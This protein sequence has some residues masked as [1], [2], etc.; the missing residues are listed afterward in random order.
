MASTTTAL[1]SEIAQLREIVDEKD[2]TL[3]LTSS[4]LERKSVELEQRSA[5]LEQRSAELEHKDQALARSVSELDAKTQRIQ[6]LEELLRQYRHRQFGTSS[7]QTPPGQ[8]HLFD[9]APEDDDD[10]ADEAS[11]VVSGHRRRSKGRPRLSA[12][13]PRIEIIHDLDEADKVCAEHGC[14]LTHIGDDV[15][16][17]LEFVPATM[18]VQRHI[19]R[20]Y[21]CTTCEGNVVTARK[22]PQPIPKSVATP[23]LLAWVAVSKFCDALPLYRQC[24]IFERLG[25]QVDRT[26][27]ANWMIKSGELVQPLINLLWDHLRQQPIVHMDETGVQV[28]AEP[29]RKAQQKSY[30]WVSTAGPPDGRAVLFHYAP[31]RSGDIPK[32]LLDGYHGALMV[33]GYAGYQAVCEA[34]AL[35]RLGCWAHARR[36][37]VEA[38]RLQ[39]KGKIGTPDQALALINQLYQIERKLKEMSPTARHAERQAMAVPVIEKLEKW[40]QNNL[41]RVAPKTALGKALHYLNEQWSRLIGY[42]EDGRYPIDNNLAENTIRPFVIG[43]KNWMFSQSVAGVKANANLY[44]LVETAKANGLDAFAYLERV[45]TELPKATSVDDFEQLLPHNVK[46]G[47]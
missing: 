34:Q 2:A 23:G 38:Q 44:S 47:D 40:L 30:M 10:V 13:L 3:A 24:Q 21:T 39:P 35:R 15:S 36:R 17:Q 42:L 43:R 46:N 16:E 20:K 31:G 29:G 19:Q 37:F 28:L 11:T 33:D 5:E 41:T 18:R 4:E 1:A 45:L 7:E 22:P 8:G 26:T 6:L 32:L 12:D 25:F 27:L 14:D 9:E